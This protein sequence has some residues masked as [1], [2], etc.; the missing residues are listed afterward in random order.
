MD[1]F[2]E[3]HNLTDARPIF[4]NAL[5]FNAYGFLNETSAIYGLLLLTPAPYSNQNRDYFDS[6]VVGKIFVGKW[7]EG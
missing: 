6:K 3:R 2:L 1:D 7:P 5:T 4:Y